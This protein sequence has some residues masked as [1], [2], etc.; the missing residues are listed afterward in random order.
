MT[1]YY[2]CGDDANPVVPFSLAQII[3]LKWTSQY[4]NHDGL[5]GP[6]SLGAKGSIPAQALWDGHQ[7]RQD[8]VL[9]LVGFGALAQIH[10][11]LFA[12]D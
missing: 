1:C 12:N 10:V 11:T 2:F 8:I 5:V 9:I 3:S 4:Y 6:F 7:R